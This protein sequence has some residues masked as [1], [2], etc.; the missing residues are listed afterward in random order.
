MTWTV[1]WPSVTR[2]RNQ[3]EI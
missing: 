2:F 3:H 1:Y